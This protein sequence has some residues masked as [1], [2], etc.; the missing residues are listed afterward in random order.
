MRFKSW[1]DEY[2]GCIAVQAWYAHDAVDEGY[3]DHI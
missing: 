2:D 3:D 1:V